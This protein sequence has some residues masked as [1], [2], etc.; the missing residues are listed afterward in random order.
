MAVLAGHPA[1]ST[2]Q[3]TRLAFGSRSHASFRLSQLAQRLH[4]LDRTTVWLPRGQGSAGYF[5]ALS[6]IGATYLAHIIEGVPL[7]DLDYDPDQ[8][9]RLVHNP[10]R[11]HLRGINDFF[12]RLAATG[13]RGGGLLTTWWSETAC[14]R[15]WGQH[16]HPDGYGGYVDARRRQVEF[17]FEHDRGSEPLTQVTRKLS[18]YQQHA[19]HT[20]SQMLV[21]FTMP[22]QAR[23]LHLRHLLD[24]STHPDVQVAVTITGATNG[25]HGPAGPIWTLPAHP[26]RPVRLTDLPGARP[27]PHRPPAANSDPATYLWAL[28]GQS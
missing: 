22:S 18:G 11:E 15:L 20:G 27:C 25:P 3:I 1:L 8:L 5:W 9:A 13:R 7:A 6:P 12:T 10:R 26:G 21:L 17:F 2:A 24:P 4:V 14:A 28:A 23:A 16:I 19:H